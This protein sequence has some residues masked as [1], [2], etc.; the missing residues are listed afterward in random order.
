MCRVL[1]G[2]RVRHRL[3]QPA[4][5]RLCS[6]ILEIQQL[7]PDLDSPQTAP[8]ED[9]QRQLKQHLRLRRCAA[10]HATVTV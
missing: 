7:L 4:C 6:E 10:V 1:Q 2:A 3:R 9:L 5:K 8:D